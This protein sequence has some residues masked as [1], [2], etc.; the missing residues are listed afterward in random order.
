V[1]LW[2]DET[3]CAFSKLK[4]ISS[5]FRDYRLVIYL[6]NPLASFFWI[7][8]CRNWM[9]RRSALISLCLSETY[10]LGIGATK[11]IRDLE[12][13]TPGMPETRILALTGM[14]T[15]EDKRKAFEAGVD[16]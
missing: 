13:R 5:E 15:L 12:S 8:R 6:C 4:D 7:C 1:A 2:M 3:E 9:V 11:E 16:G 14:S 10:S